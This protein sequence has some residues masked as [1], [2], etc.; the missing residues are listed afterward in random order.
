MTQQ[1]PPEVTHPENAGKNAREDAKQ[2]GFMGVPSKAH[3]KKLPERK[4]TLRFGHM[5]VSCARACR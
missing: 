5:P 1:L 3:G 2:S 4:V